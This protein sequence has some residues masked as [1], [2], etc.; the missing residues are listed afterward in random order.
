MPGAGAGSHTWRVWECHQALLE[1][2]KVRFSSR[3]A[4]RCA[5][6]SACVCMAAQRCSV[7]LCIWVCTSGH[8]CS[9]AV[10]SAVPSAVP[11]PAVLCHICHTVLC[12][13]T[14][15][16]HIVLCHAVPGHTVSCQ[17]TYPYSM[18]SQYM[19][20]HPPLCH[21]PPCQAVPAPWIVAPQ[22]GG[23]ATWALHSP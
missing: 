13:H 16:C 7:Y 22:A 18:P 11:C 5:M 20:C 2:P 12:H 1:P 6:S 19:L 23:R 4:H 17:V 8:S 15:P 3:G 14:V 10:P 9:L 21:I